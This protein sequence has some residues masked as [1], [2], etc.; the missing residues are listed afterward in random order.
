METE[1]KIE[2]ISKSFDN[3]QVL[4]HI[5]MD[6]QRG[7]IHLLNGKNGCGK[8][9]FVENHVWFDDSR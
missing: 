4:D 5:T 6:F 1:I 7:Y 3:Q 2:N 8:K 9:Y